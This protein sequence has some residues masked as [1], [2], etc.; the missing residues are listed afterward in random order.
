M[1]GSANPH[2]TARMTD[3][4]SPALTASALSRLDQAAFV[5]HL[6]SVYEH[7]PWIAE[8]AWLSRP[9][10]HREGLH[11]AMAEALR[12][13]SRSEQ[14]TLILAHPEL[15]GKASV[16]ATLT[17]DST[18]EQRGAGLDQCT[19]E[20]YERLQTLNAQYRAR[21]GF[22]F[23][24]AVAG[25]NR[26]EILAALTERLT[27]TPEQE[28]ETALNQIIRIAAFRLASLVAD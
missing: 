11:L 24:L 5:A 19:P 26:H 4:P 2:D 20:E 16:H 21:C 13:A 9:F 7:S 25:R 15:T 8:R 10:P 14:L 23:I 1:T 17:A 12:L 18:R 28:F 22:P 27:T 6:G 3:S